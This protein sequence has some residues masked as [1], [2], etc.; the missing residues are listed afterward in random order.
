L[1][2]GDFEVVHVVVQT[3]EHDGDIFVESL[4]AGNAVEVF[5]LDVAA[6]SRV[7]TSNV[8]DAFGLELLLHASL[9]HYVDFVL[10]ALELEDAGNVDGSA[11]RRAEDF[12]L[13]GV[14]VAA[15]ALV[16]RRSVPAYL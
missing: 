11:V 12:L 3:G 16:G 1:A 8:W 10:G 15:H 5:R 2:V 6:Q 13:G 4:T 7:G 9:A 14:S